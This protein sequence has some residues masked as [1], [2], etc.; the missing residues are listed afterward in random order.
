MNRLKRDL[1][2]TVLLVA[3][4][5]AA[6]CTNMQQLINGPQPTS[7]P[8]PTPTKSM[9]KYTTATPAVKA[10]A[11]PTMTL[12]EALNQAEKDVRNNYGNPTPT[13]TQGYYIPATP[14]PNLKPTSAPT[15][16]TKAT[17]TPKQTSAPTNTPTTAPT[18]APTKAPTNTPTPKPTSKPANP[19]ASYFMGLLSE[20][21]SDIMTTT[22]L[23][24]DL[25]QTESDGSVSNMYY[26]KYTNAES[27]ENVIHSQ[28][29]I[30]VTTLSSDTYSC[31]EQYTDI[32]GSDITTYTNTSENTENWIKKRLASGS[33]QPGLILIEKGGIIGLLNPKITSSSSTGGYTVQMD[34]AVDLTSIVK[35]LTDGT[36]TRKFNK[37][38][39]ATA[40]F[41]YK[42]HQ[43]ISFNCEAD[44]Q[45]I[46]TNL[47]LHYFQF[48][49][50]NIMDTTM[51]IEVP[52]SVKKNAR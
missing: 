22:S 48:L 33:V 27:L 20:A 1:I 49:I 32:S 18:K 43:P 46:T 13:P 9:D 8:S 3:L 40:V 52:D 4:F 51:N 2:Y 16:G 15:Q 19:T 36:Y 5:G 35:E 50:D 30:W 39:K 45:T 28:D 44:D 31:S 42:T 12:E 38:F 34:C 7:T 17:P 11:T 37:T 21:F 26:T 14:T 6:G 10:T 29:D 41:D 47:T 24:V 25:V 23:K